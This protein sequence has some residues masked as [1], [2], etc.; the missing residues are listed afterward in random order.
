MGF[1]RDAVPL[2]RASVVF[3]VAGGSVDAPADPRFAERAGAFVTLSEHPSRG[4]RG[5]MGHPMPVLPLGEAVERSARSACRDPRFPPLRSEELDRVMVEV[6]VLSPPEH[7]AYGSPD[8]VRQVRV[9]RDG[10][11]IEFMGRSGL[12]L[13]QVPVEHGWDAAE[14]LDH[15]SMKADLPPSAWTDPRASIWSFTGDIF[16]EVAPNVFPEDRYGWDRDGRR[17]QDAHRR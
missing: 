3:E 14:Y 13:P 4:L 1:G 8:L 5:C 17:G 12:L 16:S 6:T 10:L 7:L 2:A 11:M 15:L 9:G